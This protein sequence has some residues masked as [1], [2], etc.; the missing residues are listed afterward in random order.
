MVLKKAYL[1]TT[2]LE[3][4]LEQKTMQFTHDIIS[5]LN[6]TASTEIPG[7]GRRPRTQE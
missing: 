3:V 6:F 7:E 1:V 2:K 4:L 5:H